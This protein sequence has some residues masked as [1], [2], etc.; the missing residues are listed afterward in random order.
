MSGAPANLCS[1]VNLSEP[2]RVEAPAGTNVSLSAVT[3]ARR[4]TNG[5]LALGLGDWVHFGQA[6]WLATEIL[7]SAPLE[8]RIDEVSSAIGS[9][10]EEGLC[11]VGDVTSSGFEDWCLPPDLARIHRSAPA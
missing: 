10:V 3:V 2:E 5:L 11:S 4:L 9:L 1:K 7:P 8:R 6:A